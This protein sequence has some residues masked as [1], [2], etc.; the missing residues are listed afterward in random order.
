V[1]GGVPR[2]LGC[3][4][5]IDR[6]DPTVLYATALSGGK[7]FKSTNGGDS[8]AE[9]CFGFPRLG[10]CG[11]AMNPADPSIL[12]ATSTAGYLKSRDAGRTWE[13]DSSGSQVFPGLWSD[14]GSLVIELV[15]SSTLYAGSA[16]GVFKSLD[17]GESWITISTTRPTETRRVLV[18]PADP[19]VCYAMTGGSGLFKTAKPARTQRSAPTPRSWPK[20]SAA[21]SPLSTN[22]TS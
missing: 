15:D 19:S 18:D 5:Q 12:Y 6:S 1:A 16:R 17:R 14:A 7:A 21:A 13:I 10:G 3:A 22:T 9:L 4:L 8:W 2:K 20:P 11:L